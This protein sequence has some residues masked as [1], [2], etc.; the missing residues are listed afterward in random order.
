MQ[1]RIL[2]FIVVFLCVLCVCSSSYATGQVLFPAQTQPK[3]EQETNKYD[4]VYIGQDARGDEIVRVEPPR[5]T[6]QSTPQQPA[7]PYIAPQIYPSYPP[8]T[9]G[10]SYPEGSYPPSEGQPE[11]PPPRPRPQTPPYIYR[12][13][14]Q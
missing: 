5:G 6:Q 3:T 13:N 2:G 8:G 10:G 12:P 7:M 4:N 11:G 1:S 14:V 9:S